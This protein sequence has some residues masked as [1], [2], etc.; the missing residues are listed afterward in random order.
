MAETALAATPDLLGVDPDRVNVLLDDVHVT[1]RVYEDRRPSLRDV[2]RGQRRQHRAIHA[3][4]GVSLVACRGESIGIVGRNGSGKSTLLQA[5]AGLLPVDSGQ[6]Y[7]RSQP[8]L[9]GVGSALQATLSGRRNIVLGC[10]ALGMPAAEVDAQVADIV[11]FAELEEFIDLPMTAYSSGMRARLLFAIATAVVP[12]ILVIDEA[13]SVGDIA[14]QKKCMQRMNEFRASRKTMVFC[15]HSM[16]HVQELCDQA[17]WLEKGRIREIGNT[18]E[19]VGKYEDHCYGLGEPLPAEMAD[20]A[21]QVETHRSVDCRIRETLVRDLDGNEID[22]VEPLQDIIL[23]TQVEILRDGVHCYFGFALM[24]NLEEFLSAYFSKEHPDVP[25]GPFQ[26]GELITVRVRLSSLALRVGRFNVL[27][28]VADE[29]GLLW[30]ETRLS[31]EITVKPA[32]G[33][34]PLLMNAEW[35]VERG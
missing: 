26:K 3:V 25:R 19:V 14:F 5:L 33:L 8:T 13:L 32:K 12:D 27:G 6:V 24:Q 7:A 28:G 17:I 22:T 20:P 15:S 23:E 31:K 1:Y 18:E 29:S 10:L 30:Y 34:G 11:A 21:A 35:D 9:L 2:L 16:Y 4:R